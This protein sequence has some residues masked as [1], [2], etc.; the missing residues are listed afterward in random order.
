MLYTRYMIAVLDDAQAARAIPMI[1]VPS[2]SRRFG[3]TD[4]VKGVSFEI[5]AGDAFGFLG[6]NG[7]GDT[8]TVKVLC[9]LPRPTAVRVEGC[10]RP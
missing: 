6:P 2:R 1:E 5:A 10:D 8:K 4:A 3:Q 9:S 7:A